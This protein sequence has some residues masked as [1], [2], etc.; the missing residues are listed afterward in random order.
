MPASIIVI[1]GVCGCGKSTVGKMLAEKL[2]CDFLEGDS[3]HPPSNIAKMQSGVPLTDADR[4]PWLRAIHS[5]IKHH[6]AAGRRLVVS[7]S[8]L[9]PEYRRLLI[10]GAPADEDS[11]PPLAAA[12]DS[13]NADG[14]VAAPTP[15]DPSPTAAHMNDVTPAQL[16]RGGGE[17]AAA[18]EAPCTRRPQE[19]ST[20]AAASVA[21][22][23][24]DPSPQELSR[25]LHERERAGG[26]FMPA[27]L[28]D[29]Q[30]AT[31]SYC[32]DELFAHFRSGGGGGSDGGAGTAGGL[33]DCVGDA[34]SCD[35]GRGAFPDPQDIA[36]ELLR[37]LQ[38]PPA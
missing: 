29:S 25:R 17:S 7:C 6:L 1:M 34:V 35:G 22:V 20:A 13:T 24:L 16:P 8:A 4:I 18:V 5:A 38:W 9:K 28:L 2:G 32:E 11:A 27:S 30:L 26:H 3:A 19:P 36:E 37:R 31:L 33:G 21:F 23:L 15:R 10:H 14:A 12:D